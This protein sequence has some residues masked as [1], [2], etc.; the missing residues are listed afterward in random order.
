MKPYI[1]A[2]LAI[3]AH[4]LLSGA[5]LC[6]GLSLSSAAVADAPELSVTHTEVKVP[7]DILRVDARAGAVKSYAWKIWTSLKEDGPTAEQVEALKA[8][9]EA[10]GIKV[11]VEPI[12][13]APKSYHM[14]FD[15]GSAIVLPT[16]AGQEWIVFVS[17][18][19]ETGEQ[20]SQVVHVKV[21]G[22]AAPPVPPEPP[23]PPLPPDVDPVIPPGDFAIGLPLY[24][25]AMSV[26]S[27]NRAN[28]ARTILAAAA[29]AAVRVTPQE[30]INSF[31][32]TLKTSLSEEEKRLWEPWRQA[33]ISELN[34]VKALA[35]EDA[36]KWRKVY[37]E[38]GVGM[39]FV[40]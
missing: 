9:A 10:Q 7:G 21:P 19:S 36:V 2:I 8:A 25:A 14:M 26:N 1:K 40:K 37:V 27:A 35:G 6:A 13:D 3:Q 18:S 39:A 4:W 5:C 30:M 17:V 11:T 23:D 16:W 24:K 38:I 28:T 15:G 33:Y 22:G 20:S 32:E 31:A 12:S 34:R 29:S